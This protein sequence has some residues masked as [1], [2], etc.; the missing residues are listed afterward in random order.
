MPIPCPFV[1]I[2]IRVRNSKYLTKTQYLFYRCFGDIIQLA[3]LEKQNATEG[4]QKATRI[5]MLK[6]PNSHETFLVGGNMMLWILFADN[7]DMLTVTLF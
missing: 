4:V 5:K 6:I 7:P 3:I 1:L 2:T